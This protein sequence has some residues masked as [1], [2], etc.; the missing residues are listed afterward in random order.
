[1]LDLGVEPQHL[2]KEENKKMVRLQSPKVEKEKKERSHDADAMYADARCVM[3]MQC[4]AIQNNLLLW[5]KEFNKIRAAQPALAL[6][7]LSCNIPL[8][9]FFL[10]SPKSTPHPLVPKD[11][12]MQVHLMQLRNYPWNYQQELGRLQYPTHSTQLN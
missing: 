1:M 8:F 11:H 5:R 2:Q 12:P 3:L 4:S 10:S 7:V 9:N 6:P